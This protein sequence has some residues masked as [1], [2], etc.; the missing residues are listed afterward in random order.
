MSYLRFYLEEYNKTYS[1][2]KVRML[3]KASFG[4]L[5]FFVTIIHNV[6]NL[7]LSKR[8]QEKYKKELRSLKRTGWQIDGR[9]RSK[10]LDRR[11]FLDKLVKKTL[12]QNQDFGVESTNRKRDAETAGLDI[13]A[14]PSS[15][16]VV[17]KTDE[18]ALGND[19]PTAVEDSSEASITEHSAGDTQTDSG[20]K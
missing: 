12:E 16:A 8:F 13:A 9:T 10:L 4:E 19:N 20:D 17:A 1:R 18:N 5:S 6:D 3:E 2:N 14:G 7:E 15:V 11:E